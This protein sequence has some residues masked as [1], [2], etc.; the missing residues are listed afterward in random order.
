[1]K[2]WEYM[3]IDSDDMKK[4][5]SFKEPDRDKLEEYFDVLGS[6]GWEIINID[7]YDLEFRGGFS[8]V[9]KRELSKA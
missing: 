7:F 9:A 3:I 1:M 4:H 8:G 6:R 2:R 5:L